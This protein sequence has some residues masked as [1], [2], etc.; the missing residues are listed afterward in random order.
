MQSRAQVGMTRHLVV[1]ASLLVLLGC[2]LPSDA[3]LLERF[4]SDRSSFTDLV[5]MSNTDSTVIRIAADFTRI[6]TNWGWPRPD[7]LLG[8][9]H[10]RWDQY[11][12]LF[13]KLKLQD[14]LSRERLPDSTP[15]I[16]L[17]AGSFGLVNRGNS[18][19]YAYSIKPLS[20][21]VSS[22][23]VDRPTLRGDRRH[24]V[25]YRTIGNGWYL[26]YDW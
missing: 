16:Y 14:G 15:V 1:G 20:P 21:L 11:R 5:T 6:E 4:E 18:K 9:S 23:D 13:R 26:A 24:G 10:E 12:G 25:V 8:F 2:E 22:L 7:S 19:G 17:T 3:E